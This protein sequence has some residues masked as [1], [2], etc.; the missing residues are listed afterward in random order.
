MGSTVRWCVATSR[1]LNGVFGLAR[2]D[3]APD[4][5][6]GYGIAIGIDRDVPFRIHQ[7][8][9]EKIHRRHPYWEGLQ[10]GLLDGQ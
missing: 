5:V 10:V 8:L 9:V 7:A 4:E 2:F 3:V 6:V 1:G